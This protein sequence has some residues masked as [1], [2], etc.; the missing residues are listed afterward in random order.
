M[1][2]ILSIL[3]VLGFMATAAWVQAEEKKA[4][5]SSS[6]GGTTVEFVSSGQGQKSVGDDPIIAD[7]PYKGKTVTE[8]DEAGHPLTQKSYG[9]ECKTDECI[10]AQK[11]QTSETTGWRDDHKEGLRPNPYGTEGEK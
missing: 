6:S 11:R 1:K 3:V 2:K 10:R 9:A 8:R 4:K 7:D 5:K